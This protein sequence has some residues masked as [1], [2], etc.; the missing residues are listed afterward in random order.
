MRCGAAARVI[1]TPLAIAL[2]VAVL[3]PVQPALAL[4]LHYVQNANG[5]PYSWYVSPSI[6]G[7]GN[8]PNNN[9]W[10]QEQQTFIDNSGETIV[11]AP[12][13][14]YTPDLEINYVWYP[15]SPN[16]PYP[17]EEHDVFLEDFTVGGNINATIRTL[18]I[19]V[20]GNPDSPGILN[21]ASTQ[22][23]LTITNSLNLIAGSILNGT[24][25][26]R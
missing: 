16:D 13:N 1:R 22:R 12:S 24:G 8:W 6:T 19:G 21:V 7:Y 3:A 14:W 2:F 26:T 20:G 17:S 4:E 9:S 18:N 25:A 23:S 5:Q 11:S 10:S 15:G